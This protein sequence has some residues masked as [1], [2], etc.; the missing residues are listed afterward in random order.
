[1][2]HDRMEGDELTLTHEFLGL[3]LGVPRPSVSVAVS[4]LER[5]GLISTHRGLI[6][7]VDRQGLVTSANGAYGAPEAEFERLFGRDVR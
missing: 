4:L 7:I 2:A 6:T 1:M 5:H 3:M